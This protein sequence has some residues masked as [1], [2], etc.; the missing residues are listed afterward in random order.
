MLSNDIDTRNLST[1]GH[2]HLAPSKWFACRN[3]FGIHPD[4]WLNHAFLSSQCSE[5]IGTAAAVVFVVTLTT[6]KMCAHTSS[7]KSADSIHMG[8]RR[9]PAT[10][11]GPENICVVIALALILTLNLRSLQLS[12]V[13]H[14][15]ISQYIIDSYAHIEYS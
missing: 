10:S 13:T 15:F 9:V 12:N 3:H 2:L 11:V 4:L 1:I 8:F 7:Q 14:T 6:G 5:L